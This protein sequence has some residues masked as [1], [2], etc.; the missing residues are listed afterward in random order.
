MN[1]SILLELKGKTEVLLFQPIMIIMQVKKSTESSTFECSEIFYLL[2]WRR[3]NLYIFGVMRASDSVFSLKLSHQKCSLFKKLMHPQWKA[4]WVGFI[5][6]ASHV[7]HFLLFLNT[8]LRASKSFL[9]FRWKVVKKFFL[10]SGCPMTI[11][12]L[13]DDYLMTIWWLSDD[14]LMT[15]WWLS[16][17]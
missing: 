2:W 3:S 1:E 14:Y 16:D 6:S 12:W 5:G 15:I 9:N 10:R 7:N 11:R 17:D 8:S 4:L 13:S